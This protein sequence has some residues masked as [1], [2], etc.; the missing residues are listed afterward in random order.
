MTKITRQSLPTK[1]VSYIKVVS[2]LILT[3][4]LMNLSLRILVNINP[5]ISSVVALLIVGLGAIY[6]Y[7]IVFYSMANYIYKIISNELIIERVIS[8]LNHTFYNIDFHN[9]LVFE[10]YDS[11]NNDMKVSRKHRYVQ[12]NDFKRWYFIEFTRNGNRIKLI[13]EPDLGFA[14]SIQEGIKKDAN[15]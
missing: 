15:S 12:D 9:I 10:P 11:T 6:I 1:G 7:N 5:L 3:V 2:V 4:F 14:S 13:I 8:H